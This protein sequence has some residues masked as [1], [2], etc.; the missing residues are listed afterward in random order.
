MERWEDTMSRGE[1]EVLARAQIAEWTRRAKSTSGRSPGLCVLRAV[2]S[3]PTSGLSARGTHFSIEGT[4]TVTGVET[5]QFAD[6]TDSVIG[7]SGDDTF[8]RERNRERAERWC[9]Q[10][11]DHRQWRQRHHHWRFNDTAVYSGNR[12]NYA[13]SYDASSQA[14]TINDRGTGSDSQEF[15]TFLPSVPNL[16][17]LGQQNV[18]GGAVI[19]STPDTT[20]EAPQMILPTASLT[21]RLTATAAW[22]RRART[23]PS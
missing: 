11:N 7:G 8:Y 15:Q 3:Y 1:N 4:D 22:S 18:A 19:E 13:I 12:A 9:G 14:F 2:R 21:S 16:A 6:G 17:Q 20:I 23:K 10:R 5:F